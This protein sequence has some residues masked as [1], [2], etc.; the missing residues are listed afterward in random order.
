LEP[1][2]KP[3]HSIFVIE[4]LELKKVHH[5]VKNHPTLVF[6]FGKPS[7][8]MEAIIRSRLALRSH[9][10]GDPLLVVP[11]SLEVRLYPTHIGRVCKLWMSQQFSN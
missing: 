11:L 6:M 3:N 10:T 1:K 2:P 4:K 5:K 9:L 8:S 7:T